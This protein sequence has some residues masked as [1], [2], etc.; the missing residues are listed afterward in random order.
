MENTTSPGAL[1]AADVV[2]EVPRL[3]KSA[4][5]C[6]AAIY[7]RVS[8]DEQGRGYSLPTQLEACQ[9]YAQEHGYVIAARFEDEYTGTELDRPELNRLRELVRQGEVDCIIIYDLDRLARNVYFQLHLENEIH[10]AGVRI[11]YVL[12]QYKD[13]PEGNLLKRIKAE[14]AEY[15]NAQRVER[16][17]RG[18]IGRAKAGFVIVPNGRAPFGYD[19]VSEPHKGYLV[20]NEPQ[21]AVVRSIYRWLVED[22]L[23]SYAI[24]KRLW[25]QG[26]LSKGDLSDVVC[27]KTGRAE[28]SP[29]TIRRIVAHTLYKGIWHYGKTRRQVLG[30]KKVQVSTPESDWIAVPVP[31][32]VDEATWARAQ[33]CLAR[34][35]QEAKRNTQRE[36]LL[37]GMVFCSCGRRWTGRY[38]NHLKRAYYRCP[39]SESEHW[40][41]RCSMPG[42]IRQETLESAVWDGVTKFLLDTEN[43][44]AEIDKRRNEAGSAR[45]TAVD[46]IQKIELT[47]KEIDRKMDLL[48]NEMLKTTFPREVIERRMSGLKAQRDELIAK[49]QRARSEMPGTGISVEHEEQLVEFAEQIGEGLHDLD[50]SAKRRILELLELRVDVISQK[51]VR[52]TTLIST[53]AIADTSY[54]SEP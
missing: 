7:C 46:E 6:R 51:Q 35:Q 36:Y 44:R 32:I 8:T 3:L 22:G 24:A 52:V 40:R 11:E 45:Q 18:K 29:S 31:A 1:A 48:L 34:N 33:E 41:P 25:E 19:Y 38:K 47:I 39:T 15:E 5:L 10:S 13:T 30:N 53:G 43:V 49:T 9:R 4:S 54:L 26:I 17:R 23:S 14:I 16:S 50:F 2:V 37:R 21:A 28:W 42:G 12:G 27:K 20:I